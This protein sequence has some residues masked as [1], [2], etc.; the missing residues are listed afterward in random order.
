MKTL[1]TFVFSLIIALL[2]QPVIASPN[3]ASNSHTI[4]VVGD[5]LSAAYGM[6]P[7]QG[8]VTLLDK[9]LESKGLPYH[10]V[11]LSTSG[12][13]TSNG[14][15]KLKNALSDPDFHPKIVILGLGSND[16]LRGLSTKAMKDNLK[17]MIELSIKAGAEVLLIGFLI[18]TNYGPKYRAQFEKVFSDLGNQYHLKRIPF[19]LQDIIF[20]EDL[21]L[22][23][24]LH[25]NIKAQPIILETVWPELEKML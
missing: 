8:W 25:P 2:S 3:S 16:G 12:D 21:L 24:G 18:P 23:D 17:Q 5:S 11:N 22:E 13:T 19:L 4:L 14:L 15:Y 6:H 10:V 1:F 7:E 9:R 20:K